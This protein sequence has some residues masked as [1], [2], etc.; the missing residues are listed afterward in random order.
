MEYLFFFQSKW[1]VFLRNRVVL[2]SL[3]PLTCEF[4]SDNTKIKVAE[5]A[6]SEECFHYFSK[7]KVQRLQMKTEETN[8]YVIH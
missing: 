1:P 5:A 2:P 4:K 6:R 8:I 7:T 3:L